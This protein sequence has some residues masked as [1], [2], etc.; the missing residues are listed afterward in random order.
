[1]MTRT[2]RPSAK[3]SALILDLDGTLIDSAPALTKAVN[4]ALAATGRAGLD[5][6]AIRRM[7]GNGMETLSRRAL[8]ATG[9]PLEG[10]AFALFLERVRMAYR[11]APPS[12]LYPGVGETLKGLH[13]AGIRLAICTNKPHDDARTL[14][15]ALGLSPIIAALAGAGRFPVLKPDPGHVLGLLESM[16]QDPDG[17]IFV[18]DSA[19]DAEAARA[20]GLPF[21]AVSYGYSRVPVS[22]LGAVRVIDGFAELPRTLAE[23]GFTG[24]TGSRP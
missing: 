3:G 11:K 2:M 5:I 4:T 16:G 8:I 15:D 13:Q 12:P 6:I 17:A 1:M 14:V 21:I 9:G 7:I 23:I 19:V 24:L 20:A 22:N 18:G 10:E